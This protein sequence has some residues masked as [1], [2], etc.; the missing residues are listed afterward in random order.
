MGGVRLEEIR[1]LSECAFH[2]PEA[3]EAV[4]QPRSNF[5]PGLMA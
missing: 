1:N 3:E 2:G 4:A 5:G